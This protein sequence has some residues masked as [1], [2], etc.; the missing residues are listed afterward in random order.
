VAEGFLDATE[1]GNV[2]GILGEIED[3][4]GILDLP[5]V[6]DFIT[7]IP[8]STDSTAMGGENPH[9]YQVGLDKL[10]NFAKTALTYGATAG[11]YGI[12]PLLA[13]AAHTP[14]S[15]FRAGAKKLGGGDLDKWDKA[16]L[17]TGLISP[18]PLSSFVNKF[19]DIVFPGSTTLDD[20][21]KNWKLTP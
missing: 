5:M 1:G 12:N 2:S 14:G 3:L 13:V 7:T 4:D 10:G 16:D 11:L 15:F 20:P 8:G 21:D 17:A 6:T 18:T 9:Q 19:V